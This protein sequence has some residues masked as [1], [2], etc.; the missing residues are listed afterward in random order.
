M[1]TYDEAKEIAVREITS[2]GTLDNVI[3]EES[4]IEKPYGWVFSFNSK[5]FVET[6]DMLYALLGNAPIIVNK[7]DGSFQFTGPCPSIEENIR[8]YE[9]KMGYES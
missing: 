3:V 9:K 1:I 5:Q 2:D 7:Y 4:T 8:A 6:R